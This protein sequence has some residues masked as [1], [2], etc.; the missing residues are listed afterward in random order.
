MKALFLLWIL[1]LTSGACRVFFFYYTVC[2]LWSR[3]SY[4]FRGLSVLRLTR[5]YITI[6]RR[7]LVWL[8]Q[9]CPH[10]FLV[11][12]LTDKTAIRG[13]WHSERHTVVDFSERLI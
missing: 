12:I 13:L 2:A 7:E 3:I 8:G 4:L 11:A 1:T 10:G 6:V 5:R 9:A